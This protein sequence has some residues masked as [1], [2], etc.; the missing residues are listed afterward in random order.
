MKANREARQRGDAYEQFSN[1][2]DLPMTFIGL[3]WLPILIVPLV[4]RLH[5]SV[6]SSFDL[7]DYV[8][9]ALFVFEYLAKLLL[10]PNRW[11]FFK[12]HILDLVVVSVPFLRPL[13]VL[14]LL[15]TFTVLARSTTRL[16]EILTTKGLHYVLLVATVVV[17]AGAGLELS[18]EA[19]AG[20]SNP[21]AIHSYGDALWWA[22]V[23]VTTVGYGDHYPV[24]AGGRGVAVVLML[25]GIAIIGLVTASV[26]TF[27]IGEKTDPVRE[28]L[29][30][31][32][33]ELAAIRAMLSS[34]A[35]SSLRDEY[36]AELVLD[37]VSRQ[38]GADGT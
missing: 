7:V 33:G 11:Q 19:H 32:R 15:R 4:T 20:G 22:V 9:W 38:Q 8:I 5:G 24:T 31:M 2:V 35:A 29:V 6:A 21:H 30:A 1:A 10:A 14:R 16:R 26:A 27:F 28:E 12:T 18:F 25:V 3:A 34:G 13:R 17:F 36:G 23:T 37:D